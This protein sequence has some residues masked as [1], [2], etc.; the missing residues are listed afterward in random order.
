MKPTLLKTV[1]ALAGIL[2]VTVSYA[3]QNQWAWISGAEAGDVSGTYGTKGVAAP[4]NK[5]GYRDSHSGWEDA[6]GNFWIFGGQNYFGIYNDLW[7]YSKGQW[8]W[9]S[10][11][12]SQDASAV[13]GTK[14]TAASGNVPGARF[15]QSGWVDASGNFWIFGGADQSTP[16]N[17]YND[18]WEY[19]N[20]K[21]M[22]VSGS[23]TSNTAG[24][25]G[26]KGSS[27]A[28][29]GP[30][31]RYY[32]TVVVD[33]SDNFWLFG[34][35]DQNGNDYNDLW[36]F[37]SGQWTWVSGDNTANQA[38]NYG[39]K[40]TSSATNL[41]GARSGHG[42]WI[43]ATGNIWVYGGVGYANTTGGNGNTYLDDLWEFSPLSGKWTWISGDDNGNNSGVYG[44]SGIPAGTN[45]PG[46]RSSINGGGD[47]SGNFWIFGGYGYDVSGDLGTLNDVWEYTAGQWIWVSGS[48]AANQK[49]SYGTQGTA[50]PANTPGGRYNAAGWIDRTGNLWIMGGEDYGTE[51]Y[52]DLWEFTTATPLALT[53]VSLQAA[54]QGPD[55]YL[56]WQTVNEI[57]TS[58]FVV[59]R[60]T[61]GT[62]FT[63]IGSVPAIGSGNNS[64]S[65]A[66]ANPPATG[67]SYY[68]LEIQHSPGSDSY[69]S[70]VVLVNKGGNKISVYP[71]PTSTGITIKLGTGALLNTRAT[72]YDVGGR[73][74]GQQLITSQEQ[75]FDLHGLPAG[76][77][78]LQLEGGTTIRVIK[79]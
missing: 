70:I 2:F 15:G 51:D 33:A 74:V 49:Y 50:A 47:G 72:L 17:Y 60:S 77:Y 78:L 5:P 39:T 59:E 7:E 35:Q 40:G 63:D 41:P 53:E 16:A 24:D 25:Y 36:K 1:L 18:L 11:S 22:W 73:L 38:G 68:R 61:D 34:G 8:T 52:S 29:T 43:D 79:D 26:T 31:A 37:S 27:T 44:T 9:V 75:Y 42:S 19:A 21:W 48:N 55:N 30:G 69:S 56:T 62:D 12:S 45:K 54:S 65:F 6:S 14:G 58:K 3:Q 57:N 64:Y 32:T 20:G 66:D 10:G 71:N 46:A 67:N 76:L 4:G 28:A 23:K 13:Y